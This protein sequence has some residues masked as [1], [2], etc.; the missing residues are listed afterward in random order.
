MY[1]CSVRVR[2]ISAKGE[3]YVRVH[4]VPVKTTLQAAVLKCG[5]RPPRGATASLSMTS[6]GKMPEIVY[7][8]DVLPVA[9][10]PASV[11][12]RL[13]GLQGGVYVDVPYKCTFERL[14][15]YV[16][17]EK[18][19]SIGVHAHDVHGLPQTRSG[20]AV[21]ACDLW[22]DSPLDCFC[23]TKLGAHVC[24][25]WPRYVT[26]GIAQLQKKFKE[27]A[28]WIMVDC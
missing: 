22:S 14:V 1:L 19:A 10:D 5:A 3:H 8:K 6:S 13:E 26:R 18:L 25:R 11:I 28:Q 7:T 23:W 20:N 15:T 9:L 2:H 12:V 27:S 21:R 17:P 4:V 24:Y 16:I